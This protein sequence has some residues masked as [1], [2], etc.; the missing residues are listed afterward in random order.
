MTKK[1][2]P[3]PPAEMAKLTRWP[4]S[5]SY[6]F[7]TA[8]TGCGPTRF[9]AMVREKGAYSRGGS[10]T[11]TSCT[12]I[13][14]EAERPPPSVT[15]TT[16]EKE[17]ALASKSSVLASPYAPEQHVTPLESVSR[18]EAPPISNRDWPEP[19]VMAK[20]RL[21]HLDSGVS[22]SLAVSAPPATPL[23]LTAVPGGA[24][25]KSVCS[26]TLQACARMTGSSFTSVTYS[27][28]NSEAESELK[29]TDV[30]ASLTT[31][32]SA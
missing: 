25:L 13:V 6:T 3:L 4:M 2:E 10:F 9:S 22:G 16:S 24:L 30:E 32:V 27:A 31:A 8:P 17:L 23:Q 28:T 15:C 5:A 14:A 19:P 1:V 7:S 29:A 12:V 21:A 11:S 26:C 18:P 20:V